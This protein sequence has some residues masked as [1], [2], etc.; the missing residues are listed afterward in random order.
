MLYYNT[1]NEFLKSTLQMLM[2]SDIF[3]DFRLVGGT[4][5]SIQ[6][7]HRISV[8]IDLFSDIQYG[9]IDFEKIDLFLRDHFRYV[10][11]FS[12][13]EPAM[14]KSYFVGIDKENS[15]KLDLYYTDRFIQTAKIKDE[16]RFATIEEIIAM[17]IDVVQRGGRKKDFWDLHEV[18]PIYSINKMLELH[19]QRYPYSHDRALILKNFTNFSIADDDF[20]PICLHGKHW[21]FIKD[22]FEEAILKFK[23]SKLI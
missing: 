18:L 17:K 16:I 13:L 20:T 8:D 3:N 7:G 14:G 22:D 21:E 4:S 10:D 15:V 1:V 11:A 9:S 19:L 6:L 5:L 12:D 2:K 23:E